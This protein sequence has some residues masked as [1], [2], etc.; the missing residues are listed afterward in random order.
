[1]LVTKYINQLNVITTQIG[2]RLENEYLSL[3]QPNGAF[4]K[5]EEEY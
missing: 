1:M 2:R 4:C 3:S 5:K